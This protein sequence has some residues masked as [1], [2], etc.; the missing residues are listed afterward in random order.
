MKNDCPLNGACLKPQVVYRADIVNLNSNE[1]KLYIGLA[2]TTF[3]EHY[4]NH[5]KLNT[6][7]YKNST[8]LAKYVLSLKSQKHSIHWSIANKVYDQAN[9]CNPCPSEKHLIIESIIVFIT[10]FLSLSL[11]KQHC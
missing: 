4:S 5:K 11:S 8:E 3:K 6:K 2:E 9:K 1:S 10:F 7:K